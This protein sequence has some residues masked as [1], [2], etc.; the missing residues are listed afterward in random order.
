MSHND[1]ICT[2]IVSLSFHSFFHFQKKKSV[3]GVAKEI[4]RS[5][6]NPSTRKSNTLKLVKHQFDQPLSPS[7][8]Q[9]DY[10]N[11]NY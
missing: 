2:R 11:P 10:Q 6:Q 3:K 9:N 4:V 7:R 1:E 8:S 5:Y